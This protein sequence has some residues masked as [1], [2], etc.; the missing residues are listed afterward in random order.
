MNEYTG[1]STK[2]LAYKKVKV[3]KHEGVETPGLVITRVP[4]GCHNIYRNY[5]KFILTPWVP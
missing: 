5:Q 2:K 4:F 3:L 1:E